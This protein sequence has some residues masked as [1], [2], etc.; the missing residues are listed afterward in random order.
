MNDI[1][2]VF[3]VRPPRSPLIIVIIAIKRRVAPTVNYGRALSFPEYLR[4]LSR[5]TNLPRTHCLHE[6]KGTRDTFAVL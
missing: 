5:E 4:R 6:R 1:S 2:V 3:A